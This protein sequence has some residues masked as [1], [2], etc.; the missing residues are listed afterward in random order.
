MVRQHTHIRLKGE[1]VDLVLL[2]EVLLS[3]EVLEVFQDMKPTNIFTIQGNNVIN[4]MVFG[5]IN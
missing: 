2:G 1:R 5:A 3:G 4:V